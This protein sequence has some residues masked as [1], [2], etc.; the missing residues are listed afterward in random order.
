MGLSTVLAT[1][2]ANLQTR[3]P[4]T[5]LADTPATTTITRYQDSLYHYLYTPE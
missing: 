2:L 5:N 1:L 3:S 4:M